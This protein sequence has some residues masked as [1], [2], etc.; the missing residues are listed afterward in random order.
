MPS[1]PTLSSSTTDTKSEYLKKLCILP[2]HTNAYPEAS[3]SK[4]ITCFLLFYLREAGRVEM[5]QQILLYKNDSNNTSYP[6]WSPGNVILLSHYQKVEYIS[7]FPWICSGHFILELC[8]KEEIKCNKT[9]KE[10][11]VIS[12]LQWQEGPTSKILD[13]ETS[14]STHTQ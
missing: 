14:D 13:V 11:I 8:Q 12:I 4:K 6:I 1:S 9:K 5:M 7:P 2:F 3:Y 10:E